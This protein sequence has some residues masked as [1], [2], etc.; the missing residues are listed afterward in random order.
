MAVGAYYLAK[1]RGV[2]RRIRKCL[3]HGFYHFLE[4]VNLAFYVLASG[5]R[6][7]NTETK[8][9]IFFIPDQNIG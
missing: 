2:Y 3:F 7:F 5:F 8:L 6:P 9:E 1:S 4:A